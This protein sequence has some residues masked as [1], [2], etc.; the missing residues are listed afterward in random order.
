MEIWGDGSIVRD[1]FHVHDL[2]RLCVLALESDVT[3]V[4]NAGSGQG[5]SVRDLID[6][7]S[8]VTG[9]GLNVSYGPARLVDVPASILDIT[10]AKRAFGWVPR[11]ALDCGIAGIWD[12]LVR[13]NPAE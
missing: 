4:F 9:R 11:I 3:G 10:E 8:G 7:V 13:G 6:L 12:A 2:G 5:V 1:Y